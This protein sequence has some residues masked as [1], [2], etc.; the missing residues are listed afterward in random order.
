MFIAL[1]MM[2]RMSGTSARLCD[3]L[4]AGYYDDFLFGDAKQY[5]LSF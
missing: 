4:V 3:D 5:S 2:I 1:Q